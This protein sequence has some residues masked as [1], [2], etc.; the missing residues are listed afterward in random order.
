MLIKRIKWRQNVT[1][2]GLFNE[3]LLAQLSE[4]YYPAK[5]IYADATDMKALE[6]KSFDIVFSNAVI[7]HVG[8]KERQLKFSNE[9]RRVGRRY[10]VMTPNFFF[11]IEQ[12]YK[13]PLLHF[14]PDGVRKYLINARRS[15]LGHCE[16]IHLLTPHE[17]RDLFPECTIKLLRL[18]FF[19]FVPISIIA[20][21][22]S[23]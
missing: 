11:P 4:K 21:M 8:N 9:I 17:M 13:I 18:T 3:E 6:D 22:D 19:P 7:E 23:E 1:V 16:T 20:I 14:L 12:H 10:F 5:V 15:D 2:T